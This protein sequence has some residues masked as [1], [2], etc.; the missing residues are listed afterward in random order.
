MPELPLNF[1]E[2][3]LA[4]LIMIIGSFL[5]GSVGFGLGLV[6]V[7]LLLLID[8]SLVPG[9][10]LLTAT[11]LSLLISFR[12]R[13]SVDYYS[14]K[15]IIPGRITGTIIAALVLN[16]L[17]ESA[18]SLL[19]GTLVLLAVVISASGLHLPLVPKNFMSVGILSGFMATSVA[20][21]GPPLAL[22]LQKKSGSTIRGTLAIVFLVGTILAVLALAII[23][24]FGIKELILTLLLLPGI[25]IG[26][27]LS[28]K[29]THILDKGYIQ[30]AVLSISAI[31]ALVV[32]LKAFL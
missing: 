20:I 9:P 30:P 26:F 11:F 32:I 5:Q 7:P 19:F 3:S 28:A 12:E 2:F 29:T 1:A 10:V 4:F 21:G 16:Y 22:L 15:W 17:S 31:S 24:R 8:I 23:D 25:F 13:Q 18:L 27:L 14:L 6:A